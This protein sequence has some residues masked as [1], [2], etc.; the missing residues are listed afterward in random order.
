MSESTDTLPVLVENLET[1]PAEHQP[2]AEFGPNY[3]KLDPDTSY[4]EWHRLFRSLQNA[5]KAIRWW[6]GDALNFGDNAYGEKYSQ[7]I[8]EGDNYQTLRKSAYV[9]GRFELFRRRNKLSFKHHQEV[10]PLSDG[11][12]DFLFD[13]AEW[14]ID[15][16][17]AKP[18]S[19]STL[20]ALVKCPK[21]G[22]EKLVK[23]AQSH[24]W[25][26]GE[27][28]DAA[29]QLRA[30]IE[31]EEEQFEIV[32]FTVECPRCEGTGRIP[33]GKTHETHETEETQQ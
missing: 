10:S 7:A 9:A 29:Q 21:R 15:T 5:D 14:W 28:R 32:E 27:L 31:E 18:L 12:Q 30:K 23:S 11:E 17:E 1:S 2:N 22:R 13:A 25:T 33:I 26:S 3:L 20:R 16:T 24:G 8:D 6:E 4:D 19:A